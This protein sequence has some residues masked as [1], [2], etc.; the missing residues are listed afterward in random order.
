M[1]STLNLFDITWLI[2][3][4]CDRVRE[5]TPQRLP[6]QILNLARE[7]NSSLPG[8][9]ILDILRT[10]RIVNN[11]CLIYRL[12]SGAFQL[13]FRTDNQPISLTET[14]LTRCYPPDKETRLREL[15]AEL[16]DEAAKQPPRTEM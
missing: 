5:M 9:W 4:V 8:F 14:M 11:D 7:I 2:L 13:Q 15:M 3:C 6:E 12:P 10:T 16:N 1:S